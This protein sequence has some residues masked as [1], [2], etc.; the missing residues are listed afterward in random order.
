MLRVYRDKA[1]SF[2]T[3]TAQDLPGGEIIWIDLLNPTD[4]EK[5]FVGQRA[6]VH[7]PSTEA[8]SE[9]EAS[10]RLFGRKMSSI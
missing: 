2:S 9:I 8:L 4:A 6:G 1:G 5:Q 10:S 7:V 3:S